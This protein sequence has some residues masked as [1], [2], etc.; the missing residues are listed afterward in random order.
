MYP[1]ER[2]YGRIALVHIEIL[3][4]DSVVAQLS[5]VPQRMQLFDCVSEWGSGFAIS[6]RLACDTT[7]SN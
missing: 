1:R 6:R 4:M 3:T 2:K 7:V 5:R